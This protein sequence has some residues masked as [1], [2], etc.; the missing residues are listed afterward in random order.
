MRPTIQDGSLYAG[1]KVGAGLVPAPWF[2][3]LCSA[4]FLLLA[5]AYAEAVLAWITLSHW[6]RPNLDDPMSLPTAPF[7]YVTILLMVALF[8][9]MLGVIVATALSWRTLGISRAHLTWT[10]GAFFGLAV[11]LVLSRTDPGY[12][13]VWL[14]D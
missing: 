12:V 2:K 10:A 8:P 1:E 13:W 14:G 4:P 7:H 6:P 3:L 11:V 9:A 5:A